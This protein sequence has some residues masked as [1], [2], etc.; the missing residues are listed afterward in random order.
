[1]FVAQLSALLEALRINN[2][3][4][5]NSLKFH[6][7]CPPRWWE[8][9]VRVGDDTPDAES[10]G[11]DSGLFEPDDV[12]TRIYMAWTSRYVYAVVRILV[13]RVPYYN[14]VSRLRHPPEI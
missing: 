13:G 10:W 9:H 5:K 3:D 4:A 12:D 2:D 11:G 7:D 8:R 1:M 14:V 6:P